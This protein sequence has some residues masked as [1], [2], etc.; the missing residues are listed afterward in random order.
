MEVD[1]TLNDRASSGLDDIA[2]AAERVEKLEP[3]LE[4]TADTDTAERDIK[5]VSEQAAALSR[6]D[7]EVQL[8][9]QIDDLK[10]QTRRAQDELKGVAEQADDTNRH[11]DR[12]GGEGGLSTRGQAIADLT[13]P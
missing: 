1:V 9:A 13:G 4:V 2:D 3:E 7:V 11:L 5:Q 8:R 10:A 12:M 6:Q